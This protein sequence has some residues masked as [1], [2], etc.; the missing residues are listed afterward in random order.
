MEKIIATPRHNWFKVILA[1]EE[2]AGREKYTG[3]E[4]DGETER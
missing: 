3:T 1:G 2:G 4:R